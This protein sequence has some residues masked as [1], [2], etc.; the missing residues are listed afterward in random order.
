[1]HC[2]E[3]ATK[4]KKNT[5]H[6]SHPWEARNQQDLITIGSL[7]FGT[8][9]KHSLTAN[10]VVFLI[11]PNFRSGEKEANA[12]WHY[13]RAICCQKG[14]STNLSSRKKN[15]PFPITRLAVFSQRKMNVY[16][17]ERDVLCR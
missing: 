7:S 9:K 10:V 1:M 8:E 14:Q 11:Q 4:K 2:K 17:W 3:L 13:N 15:Y 12:V 5:F 6:C 16:L